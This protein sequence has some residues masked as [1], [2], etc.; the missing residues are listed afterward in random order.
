[1]KKIKKSDFVFKKP[2]IDKVGKVF[3]YDNRVFRAINDDYVDQT[4]KM[5]SSGF[6][7]EINKKGLFPKTWLANVILEEYSLVI[8]HEKI[9]N[10]NYPYEWSFDMLK[11]AVLTMLELGK[12]ANKYGYKVIDGNVSNIVFNMNRPQYFDFGGLRQL[13]KGESNAWNA[14]KFFYMPILIWQMGYP[15]IARNTFLM[16]ESF[17]EKEFFKIKYPLLRNMPHNIPFKISDIVKKIITTPDPK[18]ENKVNNIVLKNII[19]LARSIFKPLF[20]H[21]K[22][23]NDIQKIRRPKEKSEWGNYH[24]KIEPAKNK[25]FLRIIDIIKKLDDAKSLVEVGANQGKFAFHLLE[26][27]H[28]KKVIAT[29][30][31]ENAVNTMYL[32][33]KNEKV[34]PLIFDILRPV[35]RSCD[36]HI[37]ERIKC[38]I[39]LGLALTHHLILDEKFPIEYIF[40][41]LKRLTNKYII[42][43]FMPMGLWNGISAPPLPDFYNLKWFKQN[44]T[45]NFDLILD[46]KFEINR[47]VFVGKLK[48]KDENN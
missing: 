2:S 34:L 9:N 5:I 19:F 29:D 32:S 35:G 41:S 42:I 7:D 38:D 20:S 26:N 11:K 40:K 21:K 46:E 44:F 4:K 43:E 23:K 3:F 28:V 45:N 24:D 36:S 31:D 12:I 37:H 13:E 6:I 25:R 10:W 47:H 33:C 48:E 1:M 17:S 39:V 27:T 8:E 15:N 14:C 22:F 30:S 16:R 18:I